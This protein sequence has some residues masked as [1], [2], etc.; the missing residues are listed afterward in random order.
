[1]ESV[2]LNVDIDEVIVSM[3]LQYC[4]EHHLSVVDPHEADISIRVFSD[5]VME[6]L[7]DKFGTDEEDRCDE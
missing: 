5:F 7:R 4:A 2:L 6:Y 3:F 1:M